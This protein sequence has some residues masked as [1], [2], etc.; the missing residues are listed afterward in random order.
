M[1]IQTQ[2]FKD[3]F[4]IIQTPSFKDFIYYHSDSKLQGCFLWSFR[5]RASRMYFLII[6][7][8]S[9]KDV[10]Y[11]HL[12]FKLQECT[13]WSDSKLQGCDHSDSKLPGC[14]LWSFR[15]QASRI[16]VMLIQT[17]SFKDV[18]VIYIYDHSDSKLQ[19][20]SLWS[21]ILQASMMYFMIIQTPS[22]KDVLY[23]HSDFKLQGCTLWSFRLQAA[24]MYFMIIQ[25]QSFKD[26]Y[27]HSVPF[28]LLSF[29]LQASR[30]SSI[31]NRRSPGSGPTQYSMCG[32]RRGAPTTL[33]YSHVI[34]HCYRY[35]TVPFFDSSSIGWRNSFWVHTSREDGRDK[36]GE[37]PGV[38]SHWSEWLWQ[39]G[40]G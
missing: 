7:T 34:E 26:L 38:P 12:D 25:T 2:S 30:S 36:R 22:F 21:F 17:S 1:I 14:I 40:K 27:D 28:Y 9:F 20:C 31:L 4:V 37:G 11:D 35:E 32:S 19:V 5:L 6:Q 10:L 39:V 33:K 8:L 3:V 15:L 23:D 16:Y 24:R 13:L 29:R 18:R